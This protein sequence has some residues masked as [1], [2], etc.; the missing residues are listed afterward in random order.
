MVFTMIS[1]N[2]NNCRAITNDDKI[3]KSQ[4]DNVK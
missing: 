4:M 3:K 2:F 1:H